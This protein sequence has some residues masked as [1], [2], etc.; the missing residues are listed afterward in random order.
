[1]TGPGPQNRESAPSDLLL[2]APCRPPELTLSPCRHPEPQN[3]AVRAAFDGDLDALGERPE[4]WFTDDGERDHVSNYSYVTG[5]A[6]LAA[7]AKA[8]RLGVVEWLLQRGA[9]ALEGEALAWA[10]FIGRLDIMCALMNAARA[11]LPRTSDPGSE[12]G[13]GSAYRLYLK[14][15]VGK[16]LFFAASV[17]RL[18]AAEALLDACAGAGAAYAE[19]NTSDLLEEAAAS[20]NVEL[21]RLLLARGASANGDGW[22]RGRAL[23]AAAGCGDAAMVQALLEHGAHAHRFETGW[24]TELR[25]AVGAG[26]APVARLLLADGADVGTLTANGLR[27]PGNELG[28][29][30]A[31][32]LAEARRR[33]ALGLPQADAPLNAPGPS[34]APAAAAPPTAAAAADAAAAPAP[35]T[36]PAAAAPAPAPELKPD[37]EQQPASAGAPSAA[38]LSLRA[39]VL[40]ARAH[41]ATL[42]AAAA[43][44]PPRGA[45]AARAKLASAQRSAAV[46]AE[47]LDDLAALLLAPAAD[48]AGPSAPRSGDSRGK[49]PRT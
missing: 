46:L 45:D 12:S 48:G 32:V 14:S 36:A 33:A 38:A 24:Y 30:L 42:E 49:R 31:E 17:G 29:E 1:M 21:V 2:L 10:V 19:L 9:R 5:V 11:S 43:L 41:A 34:S 13:S 22:M 16:A 35:A 3:A 37:P 47:D 25:D 28:A 26:S 23:R 4:G 18:A 15:D 20:G 7:A 6:P 40:S 44:L 27:M 8:G 39:A